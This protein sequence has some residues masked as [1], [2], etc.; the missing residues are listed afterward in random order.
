MGVGVTN[1]SM[2]MKTLTVAVTTLMFQVTYAG[3]QQD[4][5]IQ[6]LRE[7][8]A[9][10]RALVEQQSS[11]EH[12]PAHNQSAVASSQQGQNLKWNTGKGAEVQLYGFLRGDA[13]YVIEG[14]DNDF[15]SAATSTGSTKDK[16]NLTAKTTRIGLNF[17]TPIAGVDIG[18]KLEADF[19]GNGSGE[20]FRIRHA[21]LTYNNW[22]F[23]QTTSNFLFTEA[24]EMI[25]FNTNIGGGTNRMPQVRYTYPLASATQLSFA[26]EEGGSQ[27]SD[28]NSAKYALPVLTA[29]LSQGFADGKGKV[30]VRGLVERYEANGNNDSDTT[31]WG[32]GAGM[33]YQVVDA[34]KLVADY[35]HVKGNSND[36]YGSNKAFVVNGDDLEQNEFNAVQI[37]ATYKILPNLRST[38][39]YGALFA[40]DN[41]E[42]AEMVT[43]ANKEVRQA[44]LNVIYTPAKPIDLGV[45]YINA[46]RETFAGDSYKDNRVGLMARYNF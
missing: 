21:Y 32:V 41:N 1:K 28:S 25:D 7:E 34:L 4:A 31:A 26:A 6:Q 8:V 42:F 33:S 30:L 36:L 9:A 16:L 45:E 14:A 3:S 40:D 44:W 46:E 15:N 17:K 19:A 24:P 10:L 38:I 20:N 13:N 12:K 23:G 27:D 39:A 2:L 5:E 35:S 37:G 43:T 18:G 29:K 22:L 11:V